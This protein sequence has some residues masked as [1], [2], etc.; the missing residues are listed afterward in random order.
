MKNRFY[1]LSALL[2]LAGCRTESVV[3]PA[4]DDYFPL[5]LNAYRTYAVADSSWTNGKLSVSNYQLREVV[6]EQFTDAAGLPAF[7][8]VR[9]R[10]ASAAAAWADDSVLVVQALPKAVLLTRDNVRTVELIYPP[11]A[12][13]G[14]N[15]NAFTNTPDTITS[16][17]RFYAASVGGAFTTPAM[18]GLPAKNYPVTLSTRATL[19]A[20]PGERAVE[21]LNA[22]YQRGLRQVYARDVG[23]V[24]R[25]RFRY[26]TFTTDSNGL[27]TLT[28]GVVQNGDSRQEVLIETGV[29]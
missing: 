18:G 12:S 25:R 8:L 6:R 17:S 14:W 3:A 29:L 22:F 13:R 9:A 28:P 5:A 19:P 24:L 26:F 2:L 1:L 15:A 27:Q 23:R 21:D 11:Q 10:R 20:K 16:R 4:L 7:R